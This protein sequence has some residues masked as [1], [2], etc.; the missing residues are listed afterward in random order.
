MRCFSGYEFSLNRIAFCFPPF[1]Y[2]CV[3]VATF[4]AHL[5]FAIPVE[6]TVKTVRSQR[7]EIQ[8]E[9]ESF[10]WTSWLANEILKTFVFIVVL[11]Q[12]QFPVF[13]WRSHIPFAF[14]PIA[15]PSE[16]LVSSDYRPYRN[17]VFYSVLARQGSSF[18]NRAC[19]NFQAFALRDNCRDLILGEVVCI[20]IIYHIPLFVTL[21]IEW[22]WFLGLITW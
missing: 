10:I 18:C 6:S 22:L 11:L 7:I 12:V 20:F 5:R 13:M 3:N 9:S 17:L 4:N 14:R 1:I 15:F 19:L 8:L 16:V 21:F 2:V